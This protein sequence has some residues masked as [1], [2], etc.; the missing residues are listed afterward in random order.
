M[1][2]KKYKLQHENAKRFFLDGL[3]SEWGVGLKNVRAA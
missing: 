2:L 3:L 1:L